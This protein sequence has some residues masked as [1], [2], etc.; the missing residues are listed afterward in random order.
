MDGNVPFYGT[1]GKEE[2]A[3]QKR[4]EPV[5]PPAVQ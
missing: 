4:G 1:Y 5:P 3:A 2:Q